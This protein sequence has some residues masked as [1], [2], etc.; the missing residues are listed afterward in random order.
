MNN[1]QIVIEFDGFLNHSDQEKKI[2]DYKRD[3]FLLCQGV[4][5]YRLQWFGFIYNKKLF[6]QTIEKEAL[7]A[8]KVIKMF[9][10]LYNKK[11]KK[12]LKEEQFNKL[13]YLYTK[14][15]LTS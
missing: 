7:E 8:S 13:M 9:I 2:K 4:F 3:C 15:N 11:Q 14:T 1:L 12:L 6:Y 10:N 5:V